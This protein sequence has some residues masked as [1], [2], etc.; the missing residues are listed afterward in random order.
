MEIEQINVDTALTKPRFGDEQGHGQGHTVIPTVHHLQHPD[1]CRPTPSPFF[2]L[3][4]YKGSPQLLWENLR[5]FLEQSSVQLSFSTISTMTCRHNAILGAPDDPQDIT[6]SISVFSPNMAFVFWC[7]IP[8]ESSG[9]PLFHPTA[10]LLFLFYTDS[11]QHHW[12]GVEN[13]II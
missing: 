1:L 10:T 7:P 9:I 4:P 13:N 12:G 3:G 8:L 6:G 2:S 11:S 5:H